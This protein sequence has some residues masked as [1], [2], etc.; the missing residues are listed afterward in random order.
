MR[1]SWVHQSP[2][3]I[4]LFFF[5]FPLQ[6]KKKH[7]LLYLAILYLTIYSEWKRLLACFNLSMF[8]LWIWLLVSNVGDKYDVFLS[9][10]AWTPSILLSAIFVRPSVRAKL[11]KTYYGWQTAERRWYLICSSQSNQRIEAGFR[12][13]YVC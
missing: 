3:A 1:P 9:F 5:C 7:S 6:K 11:I 2:S 10:R 8:R 4:I 13:C 12:V